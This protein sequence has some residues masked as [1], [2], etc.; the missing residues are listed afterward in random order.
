MAS[1]PCALECGNPVNPYDEG[2][3]KQVKG[4]VHGKKKDSLTLREDTGLYAHQHC[5]LKVKEGQSIDQPSI[6]DDNPGGSDAPG[7]F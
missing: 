3:Y 2:T 4:W 1:E 6:F 5:V 7:A